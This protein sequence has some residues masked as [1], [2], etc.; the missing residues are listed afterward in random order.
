MFASLFQK[1]PLFTLRASL[2]LDNTIIQA[3]ISQVNLAQQANPSLDLECLTKC[4]I[5][6]P[7]DFFNMNPSGM[8]PDGC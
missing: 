3:I 1:L 8:F 6:I 2:G 7:T 5:P 4:G